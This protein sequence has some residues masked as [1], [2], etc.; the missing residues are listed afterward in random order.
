[1]QEK[2]LIDL[3]FRKVKEYNQISFIAADPICVPHQFSK[4][5]DIEIAAFFAAIFAWGNR[6]TIINSA[7][8]V[9][10]WMEN[11]PY[12][13]ILQYKPEKQAKSMQ[14]FAHRTFNAIDLWYFIDFLHLH[15]QNNESLESA[16]LQNRTQYIS[17][18][19][20]LIDFRN[21]FFS[22]ADFPARTKKHISSP[23]S[24]S[25][26]KRL[27][28]FLRWMVREDQQGVD[29]G[30]WKKIP[31]MDLLI[32][33]DIHVANVSARLGLLRNN[34]SNWQNT[35]SLTEKLKEFHP[36]DPAIFD[37]ALF[38]LGVLEKFN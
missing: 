29:F 36:T 15:Y 16:F 28:M 20:G 1:M 38:S 30:I 33:L 5:Q 18:E 14:H 12:D 6:T 17:V 31:M 22:L 34:K 8:K 26:C 9:M 24:K 21:Y 19:Q 4:K 10:Q 11:R 13:F 25:A 2:V 7:N 32:P 35:I 27:N 3:L 23:Q 37:Y